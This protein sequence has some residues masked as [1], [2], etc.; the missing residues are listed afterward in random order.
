M[1]RSRFSDET[2]VAMLKENE[3][4]AKVDEVCCRH[5]VSGAR[6]S[7]SEHTTWYY[8]MNVSDGED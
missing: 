2:I 6:R 5:G 8:L 3:A 1:K 7:V 4:G